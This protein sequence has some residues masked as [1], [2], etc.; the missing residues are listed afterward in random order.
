[1]DTLWTD[2]Y[3]IR[4]EFDPL[5][6]QNKDRAWTRSRAQTRPCWRAWTWRSC[7]PQLRGRSRWASLASLG[8]RRRRTSSCR[9]LGKGASTKSRPR[10]TSVGLIYFALN[11]YGLNEIRW[12]LISNSKSFIIFLNLIQ[13]TWD[14][15]NRTNPRMEWRRAASAK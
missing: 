14:M 15:N 3:N 12:I 11:P 5:S 6:S 13:F 4:F 9:L 8:S 10:S 7:S 1:M 2:I